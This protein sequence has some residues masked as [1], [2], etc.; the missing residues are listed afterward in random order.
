MGDMNNKRLAFQVGAVCLALC[1]GWA[2][3]DEG[4]GWFGRAAVEQM[5]MSAVLDG[6]LLDDDKSAVRHAQGAVNS[7]ARAG[8]R[9]EAGSEDAVAY[10]KVLDGSSYDP[11]RTGG[12]CKKLCGAADGDCP[13]KRGPGVSEADL[14]ALADELEEQGK[15]AK[16]DEFKELHN[17]FGQSPNRGALAYDVASENQCAAKCVSNTDCVV[18]TWNPFAEASSLTGL[19]AGCRLLN[20]EEFDRASY[21]RAPIRKGEWNWK[22][23]RSDRISV[24]NY[25]KKNWNA[26]TTVE[27]DKPK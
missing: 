11:L 17:L 3:A 16:K 2:H 23:F 7:W 4:S 15:E 18:F 24:K 26:V 1:G 14:A 25:E 21:S 9:L 10:R 13:V 19:T 8:A 20:A 5:R 6:D 22:K 12:E 27:G